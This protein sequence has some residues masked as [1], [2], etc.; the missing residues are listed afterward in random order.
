MHK[1]IGNLDAEET[2]LV[3]QQA[4]LFLQLLFV[5]VDQALEHVSLKKLRAH[6][7]VDNLEKLL[8]KSREKIVN[9][10]SSPN[11]EIFL[12]L[13]TLGSQVEF[14]LWVNGHFL[15]SDFHLKKIALRHKELLI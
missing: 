4:S 13:N 2:H 12:V 15:L 1:H 3:S 9:L 5:N 11:L 14:E 7:E 8:N 10:S 6:L